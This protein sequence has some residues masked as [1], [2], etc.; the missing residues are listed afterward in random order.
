M[1]KY[2]ELEIDV[3]KLLQNDVLTESSESNVVDDPYGNS[4][5]GNNWWENNN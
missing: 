1:K 3:I 4:G 2:L 5:S